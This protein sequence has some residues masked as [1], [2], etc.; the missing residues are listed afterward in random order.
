MKY[1]TKGD[2]VTEEVFNPM[3]A[4]R[5]K[6][7]TEIIAELEESRAKAI[8]PKN[9]MGSSKKTSVEGSGVGVMSSRSVASALSNSKA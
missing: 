6:M 8:N 5:N 9:D 4:L 3:L 1:V 7:R 2:A